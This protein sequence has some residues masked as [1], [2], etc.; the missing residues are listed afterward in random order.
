MFL[1]L[2]RRTER[3]DMQVS[4]LRSGLDSAEAARD[5][6]QARLSRSEAALRQLRL[7]AEELAADKQVRSN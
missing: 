3:V 1:S 5:D 7:Q 6:V 2:A 4:K